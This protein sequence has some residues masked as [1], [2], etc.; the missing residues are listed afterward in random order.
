MNRGLY[1]SATSL[2]ANQRKM[3]VIANNI[4]NMNT[5]GFKKD[6][7]I[8]ESFPEALLA[9]INDKPD[10]DL[11]VTGQNQIT[12]ENHGEVHIAHTEN[13]Y[14]MIRTPMGVS[15]EK[16][17][18]F[19]V[20]DEGNLRTYYK[21]E[22]DE[23]KTDG[24]NLILGRDGN[25]VNAQGNIEGM[26]EGMVYY[27]NRN[28]IGTM[29]GGVKFHKI[30]SDFTQGDIVE[31]GGKTDV[32]LNGSGF[33]KVQ[34]E[35]GEV[36]YTRDGS[37]AINNEGILTTS[38][39][40]E[41]VGRQGQININGDSIEIRKNGEIVVDGAVVDSL[42]IVDLDNKE[43]LRKVGDNLYR[44]LDGVNGEE[45]PFEGEVMSGCLESSNVDS[46]KEMVNMISLLRNYESCQKAVRTQDEMLEKAANEIGRV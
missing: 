2:I 42:D 35:D 16:D 29:S 38:D 45:I 39:G 4:A 17:I 44:M 33:F 30:V 3:D 5:T 34:G 6:I 26:L 7:P 10:S 15:Y 40:R 28:I 25:P 24:E 1:I 21:N 43:Y 46:I 32:A 41:V 22:K 14:F 13:G 9:K 11:T 36:L 27:P 19:I 12:Y 31:T 23:Y 18:R 8:T 37:F 20:D